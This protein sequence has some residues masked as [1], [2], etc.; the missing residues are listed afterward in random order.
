MSPFFSAVRPCARF[1][2]V[3]FVFVFVFVFDFDY[4][5]CSL[6]A[7]SQRNGGTIR[8]YEGAAYLLCIRYC[9]DVQQEQS[10]AM[11]TAVRVLTVIVLT[12][13]HV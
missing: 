12:L 2:V 7:V 11:G 10:N 5:G 13:S 1:F 6:L 4:R 8:Y 9:C 3:V